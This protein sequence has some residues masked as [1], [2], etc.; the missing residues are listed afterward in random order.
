MNALR[1]VMGLLTALG[2]GAALVALAVLEGY[3]ARGATLMVGT[4]GLRAVILV[5][6]IVAGAAGVTALALL[7][8]PLVRG[9]RPARA[10]YLGILGVASG[11]AVVAFASAGVAEQRCQYY[12]FTSPDGDRSVVVEERAFLSEG[13]LLVYTADPDR[14]NYHRVATMSVHDGSAPM[15]HGDYRVSWLDGAVRVEFDDGSG[16]RS[17]DVPL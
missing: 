6:I 8:R 10:A 14:V 1:V 3:E 4:L 2:A 5:L 15:A 17:Q 9:T 12:A 11:A 13:H 16:W 7:L